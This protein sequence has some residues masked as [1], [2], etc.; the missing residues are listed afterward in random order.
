MTV[1]LHHRSLLVL[2]DQSVSTSVSPTSVQNYLISG[3]S[4]E[5]SPNPT[6]DNV[7]ISFKTSEYQTAEIQIADIL[8]NVCRSYTADGVEFTIKSSLSNFPSG[9]YYLLINIQDEK[10]V[11]KIIKL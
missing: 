6:T 5:I 8:G 4:I 7:V 11:R 2:P 9:T 1:T 3:T 10:I